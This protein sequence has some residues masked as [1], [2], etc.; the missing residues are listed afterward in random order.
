MIFVAE[1]F[2]YEQVRQGQNL[3]MD[4]LRI[5]LREKEILLAHAPTGLGKTASALAVVLEEA[6]RE[7]KKV[8]FIT[9]RHTQHRIAV[10]TLKEIKRKNKANFSCLDLIGKRWM[11]SQ[12]VA[13]LFGHDFNEYCR[14]VV[15]RGECEFY[16]RVR[17]KNKLQVEAEV[18]VKELQQNIY[19]TEEIISLCKEKKMCSHEI[20]LALAKKTDIIVG[21]YYYI[22]NPFVQ[23]TLFK[24]MECDLENVF[25]IVDEGHN[26]P[27][28][29]REMMSNNLSSYM[30][31]NA[32]Q[33]ARKYGYRGLISWLQELM[34]IL[35]NLAEFS[36][37]QKERLVSK[38]EFLDQVKKI[39]DYEEL[40][41]ELEL[42][43]EE[44]RKKQRKSYLGGIAA[45][46]EIW[47]GDDQ[48]YTRIIAEK[49]GPAGDFLVLSYACLDPAIVTK[50][51]FKRI[52]GGVIM[53]GTLKPTF[54]FKDLL[55]IEKAQ[56][57]E[58]FSPFPLE[59]KITLIVPE[60]SSKYSLRGEK[61]YQ[62][63]GL[64][65]THISSLIP[66][67]V[68][69]FF[70]S[71]S[72]RDCVAKYIQSKKNLFFEKS[73]MT[74]EEKDC[75]LNEFKEARQEG[76]FLLGVTGANFAEG[77]DLPGDFLNGVIVVGLPLA[78]PDLKVREIVKYYDDKFSKGWD[79]GYVYPAI[80]KCLQSAGRCIR[81][82]T[83]KGAVIYLDERFAW[84]NY[85]SC[86]P[87]EGL[88]VTKS[89]EGLLRKFFKKQDVGSFKEESL[90]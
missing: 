25:V 59:N 14:M 74:K 33:E 16:D 42:A 28:R 30:V 52:A 69:C 51:I 36:N 18:L 34:R 83:D 56:E 63:I 35:Q 50:N 29:I 37:S 31:K 32:L 2:P 10:D 12:E 70:P 49:N 62:D 19:H 72:F 9:N 48:G 60:T 7:K 11:C 4:D 84:Q 90:G 1:F 13:G 58:Y 61:M 8:F 80:S 76:G 73:E 46:L 26:L 54:M 87:R 39:V 45:F 88:I 79:Y 81:S 64:K 68:A 38:N 24:K 78:K 65:C 15:E 41:N 75:F 89:Y 22:F 82:E 21:D 57:K 55:G 44:V 86:F 27:N 43:A 5:S 67:N 47:L 23:A 40:R 6:L 53:S 85:F 77:I 20:S 66:G 17:T 3:F 71:Y